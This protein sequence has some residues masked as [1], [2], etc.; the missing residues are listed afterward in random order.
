VLDNVTV[1]AFGTPGTMRT[2]QT[3]YRMTDGSYKSAI[4]VYN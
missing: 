3:G 1:P 2:I 4:Y